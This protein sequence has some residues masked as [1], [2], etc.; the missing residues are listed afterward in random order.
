MSGQYRI[1]DRPGPRPF[2]VLAWLAVVAVLAAAGGGV[3]W[4]FVSQES[5]EIQNAAPVTRTVKAPPAN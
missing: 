2:P 5:T 3:A 1:G 4:H